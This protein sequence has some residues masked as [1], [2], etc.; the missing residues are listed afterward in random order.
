MILLS[1]GYNVRA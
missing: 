1:M